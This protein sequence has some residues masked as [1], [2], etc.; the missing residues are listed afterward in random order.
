M[1][2]IKS[3]FKYFD[4]KTGIKYIFDR[5][6]HPCRICCSDGVIEEYKSKST[7]IKSGSIVCSNENCP[8]HYTYNL[9]DVTGKRISTYYSNKH[10]V[11]KK[12]AMAIW[13]ELN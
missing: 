10:C 1:F 8:D 2:G 4:K 11:K 6:L 5:R 12:V 3:T 7:G 9:H 13:N